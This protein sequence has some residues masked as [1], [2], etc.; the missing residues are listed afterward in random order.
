MKKHTYSLKYFEQCMSLTFTKIDTNPR[1]ET[2]HGTKM[3]L[4]KL[5]PLEP[6]T[7]RVCSSF[8]VISERELHIEIPRI[9]HH[10]RLS[11]T[12]FCGSATNSNYTSAIRDLFYKHGL[13]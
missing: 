9:M 1:L 11:Y 7:P 6:P 2:E 5:L 13:T 4:L 8:D 12:G 10:Y 3:L